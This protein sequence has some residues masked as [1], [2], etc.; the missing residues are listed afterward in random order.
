VI[1]TAW[2]SMDKGKRENPNSI[3]KH[4]IKLERYAVNWLGLNSKITHKSEGKKCHI[5]VALLTKG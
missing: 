1:D 2:W 3:R 4:S 5:L